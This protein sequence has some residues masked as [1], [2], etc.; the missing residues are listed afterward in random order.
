MYLMVLP[1]PLKRNL[2]AIE[3]VFNVDSF[4]RYLAVMTA[5]SS[6]DYYAYTGNNFYLYHNPEDGRFE[7][8]PWDQTWGWD[9]T[10]P[11]FERSEFGLIER[12]PLFDRLLAVDAYKIKFAAY[13]DLLSRYWFTYDNVQVNSVV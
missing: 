8:I 10:Q 3:T 9:A 1:M 6:W 4:L 11:L 12:A 2:E 13:L 7:W 5:V